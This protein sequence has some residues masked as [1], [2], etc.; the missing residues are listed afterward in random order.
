MH[1]PYIID[2]YDMS[3]VY[4]PV[5]QALLRVPFQG[6]ASMPCMSWGCHIP[7]IRHTYSKASSPVNEIA[8]DLVKFQLQLIF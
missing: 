1:A 8:T 5:G 7:N 2:V 3:P 4:S 6:F